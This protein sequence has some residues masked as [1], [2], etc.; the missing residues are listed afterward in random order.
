MPTDDGKCLVLLVE[1]DASALRFMRDLLEREGFDVRSAS[2]HWDVQKQLRDAY[3]DLIVCESNLPDA[4]GVHL[5]DRLEAHPASRGI[6][7]VFLVERDRPEEEVRALHAGAEDCIAKPFEG[8]VFVARI[9]AV[10]RRLRA[11]ETVRRVDPR[12]GLLS[13]SAIESE[14]ARELER[15]TRYERH[16]ALLLLEAERD[17]DPGGE[18]AA[19]LDDALYD[20]L[21]KVAAR[22]IRK[23]D[24]GGRL[25][26]RR[27]LVYL[28]ETGADGAT[29]LQDR[30][31]VEFRAFCEAIEGADGAFQ[32]G[33]AE[34]P[35][36]GTEYEALLAA[37][38]RAMS[39]TAGAG[40]LESAGRTA[41]A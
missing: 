31:A 40:V 3:V 39:E 14:I 37:A 1:G 20:G 26:S 38:R 7:F 13:A 9:Q 36:D 18:A 29:T 8:A 35:K 6:P 41:G 30:I 21:G 23:C 17:G 16:A 2:S 12:T 32:A 33:I 19:M 25:D 11:Y 10:I 27:Y 34:A 24:L 4:D 28:P 5:H 22:C 15:V